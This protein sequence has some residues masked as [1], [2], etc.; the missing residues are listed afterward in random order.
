MHASTL[1]NILLILLLASSSILD[2]PNSISV[3]ARKLATSNNVFKVELI[4]RDSPLSPYYN[5]SMTPQER[6]KRAPLGYISHGHNIQ[7]SSS[8]YNLN[9]EK[10]YALVPNG[11]GYLMKIALGTPKVEFLAVADTAFFFQCSAKKAR[12]QSISIKR[13]M[14]RRGTEEDAKRKM[15]RRGT[16][17]DARRKMKRRG[18]EEEA[19]MKMRRGRGELRS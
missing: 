13:K 1:S 6:L 16:E 3:E 12:A 2:P 19:K 14:K 10:S 7:L 11:G 5:S 9:D 15:K 4:H 8:F 17:E 18:T